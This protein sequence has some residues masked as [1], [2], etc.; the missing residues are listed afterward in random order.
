MCFFIY[1]TLYAVCKKPIFKS[2]HHANH[3]SCWKSINHVSWLRNY[4]RKCSARKHNCKKHCHNEFSCND[5]GSPTQADH[6]SRRSQNLH[7]FLILFSCLA[8]ESSIKPLS[9]IT[10]RNHVFLYLVLIKEQ[11]RKSKKKK[12][13]TLFFNIAWV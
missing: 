2:I 11:K 3:K 12:I 8:A 5:L 6:I 9:L 10:Y 13:F 7:V 1:L 4:I